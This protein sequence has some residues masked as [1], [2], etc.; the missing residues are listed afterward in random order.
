MLGAKG[1]L[2]RDYLSHRPVDANPV[3]LWLCDARL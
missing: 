3:V 1:G 2:Y